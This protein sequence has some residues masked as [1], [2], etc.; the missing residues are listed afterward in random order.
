MKQLVPRRSVLSS[1]TRAHI[2]FLIL[3]VA[4]FAVFY[5]YPILSTAYLSLHSWDGVAPTMRYVGLQNYFVLVRQPRFLHAVMNNMSWLAFMLLG[6]TGVGLLLAALLDR[7]LRAE[8]IYRMIFFLPFTIPAVAVAAIWRWVYEP[9]NGLLTAT[10]Q[11]VGLGGW[12]QNWLGDP[13]LV[14]YALMG[15]VL[16]WT[17]GFA[18]LVFFAG[19]RNIPVE[20]IEA[21]RIEGA[22]PWQI[23]WKVSFPLLW[24]STIIVLGMAAID[25]MR[26]FDVIWATTNGG[27]AYASEVLA[28]QMYDVAFGRFEMGKA[29]AISVFLLIIAGVVIMPYIAAMSRRVAESEAE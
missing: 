29:S 2:A 21:A 12:A 5:V 14:T 24:P 18:F 1:T 8:K 28:T 22:S 20:F 13:A 7:G 16:W 19:L 25:A 11:A 3:P 10:L 26:L 4:L 17:T 6:P 23:F 9:T 27:P 15:A